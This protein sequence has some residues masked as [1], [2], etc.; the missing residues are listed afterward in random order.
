MRSAFREL[1][2]L[3]RLA[4]EL[5]YFEGLTISRIATRLEQAPDAANARIRTGLRR[6]AG[7]VGAPLMGETR[8]D[9]PPT[10]EL[11]ALYALGA[12]NATERAAFDAHLEVDREA[13]DE[14]LLVVA[15]RAASRLDGATAR[16]AARP[17]RTD[18]HDR[19]R[20]TAARRGG[21]GGGGIVPVP[22]GRRT[23]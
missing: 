5:A 3:E 9:T 1:P 16:A 23:G 12:L 17:A 21:T 7:S 22:G 13:V 11:A 19:D 15:R 2:P 20:R 8:H 14:V 6:L 10:R 4:I 18:H